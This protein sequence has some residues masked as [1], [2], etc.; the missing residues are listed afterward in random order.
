MPFP[1][2]AASI[3]ICRPRERGFGVAAARPWR[4]HVTCV[5][6]AVQ[7]EAVHRCSGTATERNGPGSAAQH[8]VL[9]RARETGSYACEMNLMFRY[10]LRPSMPP[11][12]PWPDSFT[13]PNGVSGVETATELTPTMPDWIASPIAEAV[14]FDV[15]KA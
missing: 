11:S 10:A 1:A 5:P 14:A 8:C 9:R 15:V 2:A 13:P 12:L 3:S 7:R 6:D 4:R